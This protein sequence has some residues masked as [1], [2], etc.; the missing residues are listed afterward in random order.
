[1]VIVNQFF[2][3]ADASYRFDEDAAAAVLNCFTIWIAGMIDPLRLVSADGG[4]DHFLVVIEPEIICLHIVLVVGNRR[5]QNAAASIL[6]DSRALADRSGRKNTATVHAGFS[7][8]DR[9]FFL[10]QNKLNH[11]VYTK[12]ASP[13]TLVRV[14][15]SRSRTPAVKFVPY[16][17]WITRMARMFEEVEEE[18]VKLTSRGLHQNRVTGYPS[19]SHVFATPHS[20]RK[21]C[22]LQ[23]VDYAD[24]TDET[25]VKRVEMVSS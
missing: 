13:A 18:K 8:C 20:R 16:K 7:D 23:T 4:V 12:T 5:P 15:S 9:R 2:T 10:H 3:G 17:L 25:D 21:V 1:M 19:A 11:A 22:S 24:G 14:T 6:D